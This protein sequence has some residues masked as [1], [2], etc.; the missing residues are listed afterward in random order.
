MTPIVREQPRASRLP[1]LRSALRGLDQRGLAR[2]LRGYRNE[3]QGLSTVAWGLSLGARASNVAET[4]EAVYTEGVL[5]PLTEL[6]LP[7]HARVRLIIEPIGAPPR[8]RAAAVARL[9]AGI[10]GMRFLSDRRLPERGDLHDP[11]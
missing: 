5:K 6:N 8:D 9:K 11:A 4:I 3:P 2:G 10:A 7:D 1:S